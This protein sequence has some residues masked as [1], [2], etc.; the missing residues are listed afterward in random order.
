MVDWAVHILREHNREADS[1]AGKGV[2]GRAE[3]MGGHCGSGL[4]LPVCVVSG[5]VVANVARVV[6]G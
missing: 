4:K 5:T 2:K 3:I 6:L 1:W